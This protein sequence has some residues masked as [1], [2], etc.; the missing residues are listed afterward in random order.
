MIFRLE[1]LRLLGTAFGGAVLERTFFSAPK[2]S[3]RTLVSSCRLPVRQAL[4]T[5]VTQGQ[6]KLLDDFFCIAL[7]FWRELQ[8]DRV[9]LGAS[10]LLLSALLPTMVHLTYTSM[11][12]NTRS[13]LGVMLPIFVALASQFVGYGPALLFVGLP[14]YLQA[15]Y[16]QAS[17]EKVMPTLPTP[18]PGIYACN[19]ALI[20]SF[21][22]WLL[23]QFFDVQS[24]QWTWANLA[25]QAYPL[26]ILAP[27]LL[28]G[29]REVPTPSS[30]G[31]ARLELASYGAAE[32]S[33]CFERTWAYKRQSAL[34]ST[35]VYWYGINRLYRGWT[36]DGARLTDASH[37][38]LWSF[39]GTVVF[40]LLARLAEQ[41]STR[42]TA[43]VQPTTGKVRSEVERECDAALARAPAGS[44]T[45]ETNAL[46]QSL[47]ALLL[48]PGA[49]MGLWWAHGE[50]RA[51]WMARRSWRETAAT[52]AKKPE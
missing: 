18:A 8:G 17:S 26:A 49:A 2:G 13:S 36:A 14:P 41:T 39:A 10:C 7:P 33:Y 28:L 32:V 20:G 47:A 40:L 51:G 38:T 30:E 15:L 3:L 44:P 24:R 25:F 34:V 19:L 31:D 23:Q 46:V 4:V 6:F 29:A 48:G 37:L 12:P 11:S 42:S 9:G 35:F 50:E 1:A 27:L 22:T 43:P 16:A 21:A 52:S 45:L 5:D